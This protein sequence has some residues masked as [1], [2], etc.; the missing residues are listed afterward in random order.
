MNELSV[1]RSF[2]ERTSSGTAKVY[3]FPQQSNST[4]FKDGSYI[5]NTIIGNPKFE[6]Y[7][8]DVVEGMVFKTFTTRLS[9]EY[10]NKDNPFDSI[11]L[12]E[13]LPDEIP[14]HNIL[15][16]K[17]L[18]QKIIDKSNDIYFDDGWDD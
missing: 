17:L 14:N 2:V 7:L 10:I 5:I 9:S 6:S 16:L 4:E 3:P 15:K 13:L 8:K 1:K 11:Y 18:A 12:S